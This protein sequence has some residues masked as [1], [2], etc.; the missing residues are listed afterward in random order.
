MRLLSGEESAINFFQAQ[1][2]RLEL[3][4]PLGFC[5]CLNGGAVWIIPERDVSPLRFNEA[6]APLLDGLAANGEAGN[7]KVEA[8]V[9]AEAIALTERFPIYA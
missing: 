1:R 2:R 5:Q 4:D 3:A 6:L 7:A 8:K 9:K